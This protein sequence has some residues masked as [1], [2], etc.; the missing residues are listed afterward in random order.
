MARGK[1]TRLRK[2]TFANRLVIMTK[3]PRRGAVKRR[4]A[5]EIGEGAALRFY[6]SCLSHSLTRLANV[7]FSNLIFIDGGGL[8]VMAD[9]PVMKVTDL[10]G[11]VARGDMA[12]L[13]GE[14]IE[15]DELAAHA[16]TVAYEI[17]TLL[18]RRYARRYRG[19]GLPAA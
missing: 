8:L 9:S 15:V 18:G 5:G 16:G 12:T 2:P 7:D 1:G 14:A 19:V 17:L 10:G 11:K 6:R 13:L 3:S 4:L